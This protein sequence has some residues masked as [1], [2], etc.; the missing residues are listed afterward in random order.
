MAVKRIRAA[1]SR[2]LVRM[3]ALVLADASCVLAVW[4]AM[5]LLYRL[6]GL[7]N[8][9]PVEYLQFWPIVA[10]FVWFNSLVR[11]YHGRFLYPGAPLGPVEE[12]R[13]LAA[14]ALMTHLLV[15]AFLGFAREVTIVSRVVLTASGFGVAILSQSF[16]NVVRRLMKALGVGQIPAFL[17]GSGP[18]A[19]EVAAI[20]ASNPHVG[21]RIV[22]T[23]DHKGL[24]VGSLPRLGGLRDVVGAGAK[25]RVKHLLVCED[26]RLFREQL[27]GFTSQ[28]QYVDYFPTGRSF[29]VMGSRLIAFGSLGGVELVNQARMR[30]LGWE[31][32]ALD[33]CVAVVAAFLLAP[34][35]VVIPVLIKLTSRGPVF[36]RHHRLGRKGRPIRIWKF[37]SMYADADDR[38]AKM[39]ESDPAAA[40]EWEER[41][42]LADDA[43][44]TPLGRILRKTSLDELPQLFNVFSGEMA[45]IGPR[46]I[47]E[48]EVAYYGDSYRTFSSVRPGI[49]GLWQVSG[50]SDMDYARRVALDTYYVLNWSP[51]TDLWILV[52]TVWSVVLMRGAC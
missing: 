30:A 6:V 47:V 52:R 41:F 34:L 10:I 29:P 11:L 19:E 39:L 44:V 8:Y 43:R 25:A 38:L 23:F 9:D 37:R 49:T 14:S 51:W 27:I 28:F 5:V 4:S 1:W 45:L 32:V 40:A 17:V 24:P 21:Y 15:M 50:R 2:G 46:P 3:A 18:V 13:R 42:K 16:R 7:G 36:Y 31:K 20:C 22:G 12:F 35:F 26:E 48:R 33:Y